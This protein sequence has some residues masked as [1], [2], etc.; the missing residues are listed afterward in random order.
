M[1][2]FLVKRG[3][4][5]SQ[6]FVLISQQEGYPKMLSTFVM[7]SEYLHRGAYQVIIWLS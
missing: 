1:Q 7:R 5:A 6:L 4:C 3:E 2:F